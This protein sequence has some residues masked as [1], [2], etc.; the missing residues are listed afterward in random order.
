MLMLFLFFLDCV[1]FIVW[2]Q[3]ESVDKA[4]N[5]NPN[6]TS[7][8]SEVNQLKGKNLSFEE[9]QT[10]FSNLAGGKGAKYAFDVLRIASIPPNT[11]LHLLGHVVGD[12]LYKQQGANGIK[13]CTDEFRNA[14]SHSIVVGLLTEKGEIA[15]NE[16]SIACKEA[17]GGKGAYTMCYHGLGHGV[18]AYLGY[19]FTKSI[20][21]CE[22]TGT[23]EYSYQEF[24][25]CIGGS[26]MEMISGGFHDRQLWE[27]QREIFLKKDQPLSICNGNSLPEGA[28]QL[29]LVYLTPY[30]F[31]AVGAEMSRPNPLDF[32]KAFLLCNK[33]PLSDTYGREA[34][35]GGFGK[36]FVVLARSRD[37]RNIENMSNGELMAVYEWC[38]LGKS[39]ESLDYCIA[40]AMNS[41]YWGGENNKAAAIRFCNILSTGIDQKTC[42][43]ELI[44]AVSYYIED[45]SYRT[46]FCLSLPDTF[47]ESCRVR[48]SVN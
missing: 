30:L 23:A 29:C 43:T 12:E 28:R 45:K 46:Q 13:I 7:S 15:L 17:P 6:L 34:C 25:Q 9:L 47:K 19:D 48:L 8:Y 22:M 42:F 39:K 1:L 4:H 20:E 26:V 11:D 32:E 3:V 2:I 10:F 40:S 27:K 5:I 33:L 36:E 41:I 38:Q 24:Y 16:I 37:V 21:M 44:G 35:Y 18:L 31:E 14:C